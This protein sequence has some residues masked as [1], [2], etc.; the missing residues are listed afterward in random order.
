M[1]LQK[2]AEA[3]TALVHQAVLKLPL[4]DL[5]EEL[6]EQWAVLAALQKIQEA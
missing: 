1:L 4:D 5:A 3:Q 2:K 6:Q